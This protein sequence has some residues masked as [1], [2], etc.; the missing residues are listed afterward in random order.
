MK[1]IRVIYFVLWVV[2]CIC[3]FN[4]Y[5]PS[6]LVT[7]SYTSSIDNPFGTNGI[8]DNE[9]LEIFEDGTFKGDTWGEGTWELEHGLSGTRIDFH[10]DNEGYNSYFYRRMYLGKPR[11]VIFRD[12][13]SE[14]LKTN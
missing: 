3:M 4:T 6:W 2:V 5:Y 14:F 13:G 11:I 9:S 8:S 12:L 10:F 1:K 7:G